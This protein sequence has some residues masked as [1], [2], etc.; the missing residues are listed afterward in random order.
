[1]RKAPEVGG[2]GEGFKRNG[3]AKKLFLIHFNK[4]KTKTGSNMIQR[5]HSK[6]LCGQLVPILRLHF[7]KWMR[8]CKSLSTRRA[9][10]TMQSI[11]SPNET[12][13]KGGGSGVESSNYC[14]FTKCKEA[15]GEMASL[16][17]VNFMV[18]KEDKRRTGSCPLVCVK[19]GVKLNEDLPVKEYS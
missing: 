3:N 17:K 13:L 7:V 10:E 12:K 9:K 4:N 19:C 14:I 5:I 2:W 8:E 6:W 15:V 18:L 11:Y 16:L 1:M